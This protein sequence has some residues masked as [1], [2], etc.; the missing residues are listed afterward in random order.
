MHGFRSFLAAL[1]CGLVVACEPGGPPSTGTG[2]GDGGGGGGGG[3]SGGG[4]GGTPSG[5]TTLAI[6]VDRAGA[7]PGVSGV[8]LELAAVTLFVDASAPAL[9]PETPCDGG[10][11][12]T[13]LA[14]SGTVPLDLGSRGET[15]LASTQVN[16][17]S[18][19]EA[20][21][22]LRQ[23]VLHRDGRTYKVHA[24]ALC[25]MPDGLQ[26]TVVA[27]RPGSPAALE[28]PGEHRLVATFDAR[29]QLETAHVACG[30]AEPEECRTSDD[31]DDD[32]DPGT[33]LRYAFAPAFPARAEG[34]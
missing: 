9:R 19:R 31:P 34:P 3:G 29:E 27:L 6:T 7:P 8:D 32:G 2:G 12:G 16:G 18:L 14:R 1:A 20:W 4:G 17:G 24:T 21:I 26:Y 28:A 15:P 33:R 5:P 30:G 10:G 22:V 13:L 11:A 23:G 25:T